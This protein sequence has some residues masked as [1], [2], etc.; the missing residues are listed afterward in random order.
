MAKLKTVTVTKQR[1]EQKNISPKLEHAARVAMSDIMGLKENEEVLITTNFGCD[2]FII[3]RALYDA[4]I[5]MKGKPVVVV[6][7]KKSMFDF[8][9]RLLLETMRAEPD[10]VISV[11]SYVGGKD[12]YG[13]NIGYVGRDGKKYQ[14][15]MT[16]LLDGDRGSVPS[17]LRKLLSICSSA[18][19]PSTMQACI[20]LRESCPGFLIAAMKSRSRRRP[21]LMRP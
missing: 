11:P 13:V 17:G 20:R 7:E 10:I 5:A 2:G 19:C 8:A 1:I 4:T 15:L 12:P 6:Q 16:K 14:S 9:E 21:A 3:A 18:A